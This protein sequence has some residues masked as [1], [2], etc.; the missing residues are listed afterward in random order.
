VLNESACVTSDNTAPE[1]PLRRSRR[2]A[3]APVSGDSK[4]S[5]A[6]EFAAAAAA[7]NFTSTQPAT[8][9]S[10]AAQQREVRKHEHKRGSLST[11]FRKF[12]AATA[13]VAAA[14]AI[15]AIVVGVVLP[16]A[17]P[18]T[19]EAE[20]ASPT[21]DPT[22][23][24]AE[25]QLQGYVAGSSAESEPLAQVQGYEASTYRNLAAVSGV[26]TA[27]AFFENDITADIQYPFAIGTSMSSGFGSRWGRLHEGIDFTPGLGAPI[28]AI[29][30][31]VVT[32]ATE[33]GG[34]Y[35]VNIRIQ[36]VIDGE[37]VESHYAHMI[38]GSMTVQVGD[39]VHV[40]QVIGQTGNTGRSTG[41][42]THFEI[43]Y[44]GVAVDPQP[45]LEKYAGTHYSKDEVAAQ[46]ALETELLGQ[47][48]T[49]FSKSS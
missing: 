36:H 37:V 22:E 42:H 14:G 44:N 43:R 18:A 6:D 26:S 46:E 29:A 8:R 23:I 24:V 39:K 27:G 17:T 7:L 41:A 38:N 31:G 12:A 48:F 49:V 33:A 28:Q 9:R 34:A 5:A 11:P 32:E 2:N 3:A 47:D 16:F 4:S 40:G 10:I 20:A 13:S 19:A 30:D 45:W 1:L 21:T 15:A 25:Q 35:G